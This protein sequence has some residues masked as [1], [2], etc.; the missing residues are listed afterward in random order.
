MVMPGQF[1]GDAGDHYGYGAEM[2]AKFQ[3]AAADATREVFWR[4]VMSLLVDKGYEVPAAVAG[5]DEALAALDARR[6]HG[7]KTTF[8]V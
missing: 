6:P 3:T 5:A 7:D 8:G 2:M 1:G 4:M